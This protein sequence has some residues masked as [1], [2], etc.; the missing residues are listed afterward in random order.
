MICFAAFD[1]VLRII[2]SRV[3]RVPFVIKI[4][5]MDFNN[6]SRNSSCF[7][8]PVDFVADFKFCFHDEFLKWL[9]H[10]VKSKIRRSQ[11]YNLSQ[12]AIARFFKNLVKISNLDKVNPHALPNKEPDLPQLSPAQCK[13]VL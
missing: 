9:L 8:I 7:R 10:S 2:F 11:S 12:S 3:M 4:L 13:D 5:F 1:F 6:R